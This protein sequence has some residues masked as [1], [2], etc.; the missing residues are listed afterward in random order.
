M[1]DEAERTF[2]RMIAAGVAPNTVAYSCLVHAFGREGRL[3][4]AT[5]IFEEMLSAEDAAHCAPD[6]QAFNILM[7]AYGQQGLSSQSARVFRSMLAHGLTPDVVTYNT[8]IQAYAQAGQP[9]QAEQVLAH[10]LAARHCLPNALT[11]SLLARA[12]H[13]A[14][15][16]AKADA[17]ARGSPAWF[18]TYAKSLSAAASCASTYCGAVSHKSVSSNKEDSQSILQPIPAGASDSTSVGEIGGNHECTTPPAVQADAVPMGCT[19]AA[20]AAHT[21]VTK[22]NCSTSSTR[23]HTVKINSSFGRSPRRPMKPLAL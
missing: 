17:V 5:R 16:H 23:P 9:R 22:V 10:M 13:D 3:E 7:A 1:A 15:W 14:G 2:R 12:Y 21:R 20:Q 11:K 4:D 6:A 19:N 18:E 8:L